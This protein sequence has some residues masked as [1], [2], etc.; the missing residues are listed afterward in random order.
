MNSA[1]FFYGFLAS[2]LIF[3]P[4]FPASCSNPSSRVEHI[5]LV[6]TRGG[7]TMGNGAGLRRLPL[8]VEEAAEVDVVA[9]IADRDA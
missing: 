1:Q 3:P 7:R 9:A 8:A 5:D 2:E 4:G 6:E